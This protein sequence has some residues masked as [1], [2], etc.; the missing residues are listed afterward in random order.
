MI[1]ALCPSMPTQSVLDWCMAD[2]R[3]RMVRQQQQAVLAWGK[4]TRVRTGGQLTHR[5]S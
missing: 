1:D 5:K 2:L 3:V 4:L